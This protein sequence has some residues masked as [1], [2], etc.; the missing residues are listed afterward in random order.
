MTCQGFGQIITDPCYE[1]LRATAGCAPVARSPSRSPPGVDTGT[2]IQLAGEGEVGPGAGPAGDL[3]VEVAVDASTRC[4]S[5]AA[6]TCTPRSRS[7]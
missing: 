6:T 3:Y 5:A 7:R 1:L 2:R 4:S